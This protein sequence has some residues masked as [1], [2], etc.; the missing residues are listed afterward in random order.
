MI[1]LQHYDPMAI[2]QLWRKERYMIHDDI[3][4][5]LDLD[6]WFDSPKSVISGIIFY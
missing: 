5:R 6:E 3:I 1:P 2:I 4:E